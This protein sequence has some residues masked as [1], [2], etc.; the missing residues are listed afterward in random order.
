MHENL[1]KRSVNDGIAASCG[2]HE[3]LHL[4]FSVKHFTA[5]THS[6]KSSVMLQIRWLQRITVHT[7]KYET[8]LS[9][10]DIELPCKFKEPC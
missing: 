3:F 1:G 10:H 9:M 4:Q 6:T 7:F 5:K 2:F 8:K